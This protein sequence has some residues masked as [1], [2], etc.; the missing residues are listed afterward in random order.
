MAFVPG[1]FFW[2][3][4]SATKARFAADV[5]QDVI[6]A[7]IERAFRQA[8]GDRTSA[9]EVQSD[10]AVDG[11][12][13]A[14]WPCEPA[15]ESSVDVEI[16]LRGRGMAQARPHGVA[17]RR[18]LGDSIGKGAV[19]GQSAMLLAWIDPRQAMGT[20]IMRRKVFFVNDMRRLTRFGYLLRLPESVC[21]LRSKRVE[22]GERNGA[23][24]ITT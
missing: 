13:H 16:V 24:G 11:W 22:F 6:E 5:R 17:R 21:L 23:A 18:Q 12:R 1:A 10:G 7:R 14:L 20:G 9:Q 19:R 3:I 2:P 8:L 15:R 4:D